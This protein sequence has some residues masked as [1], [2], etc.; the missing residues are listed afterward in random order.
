RVP[1]ATKILKL[2]VDIGTEQRQMV[3]GIAE[4]YAPEDLVGK[5]LI[6][7]VNLQPAVIRG[8]ESQAMLLAAITADNKAV[9]PFFDRD[10]P[11]GAIVK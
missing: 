5:K 3:A 11:A 6:V 8:I 2:K 7:I 4:T 10:I 9:V 1:G